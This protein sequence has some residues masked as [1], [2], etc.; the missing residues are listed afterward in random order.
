MAGGANGAKL[1]PEVVGSCITFVEHLLLQ[2][3][4]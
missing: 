1:K 4:S 2:H 3:F